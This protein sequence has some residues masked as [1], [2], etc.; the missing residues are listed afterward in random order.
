[1]YFDVNV[2]PA[3]IPAFLHSF[4][5][6]TGVAAWQ[7]R[8]KDFAHQVRDNPLIE[9]Y[10]DSYFSIERSMIYVR[11]YSKNTGRIPDIVKTPSANIAALYTFAVGVARIFAN[12]LSPVRMPCERKSRAHLTTK[13]A[14][15][16]WRLKYGRWPISWRQVLTSSF[17]TF[18]REA[19]MTSS[20]R[21]QT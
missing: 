11:R 5:E 3:E 21:K 17:T 18:A 4:T 7:K 13:W 20:S 6:I 15:R 10:L 16:H 12:Y 8:E 9:G 1:M 14:Y 2:R 19:V